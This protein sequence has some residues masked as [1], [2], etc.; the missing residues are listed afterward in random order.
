[1]SNSKSEK[2]YGLDKQKLD[3]EIELVIFQELPDIIEKGKEILWNEMGVDDPEKFATEYSQL[4]NTSF[5]RNWPRITS[6]FQGILSDMGIIDYVEAKE[7]LKAA[8]KAEEEEIE[9]E[10]CLYK[11]N[12][13]EVENSEREKLWDTLINQNISEFSKEISNSKTFIENII[14][15]IPKNKEDRNEDDKNK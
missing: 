4:L 1:M 5:S 15:K 2:F 6:S 12:I 13:C 8:I 11:K 7:E 3:N 9:K 14:K 10:H